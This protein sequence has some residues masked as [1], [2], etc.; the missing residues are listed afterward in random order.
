MVG[1]FEVADLFPSSRVAQAMSWPARRRLKMMRRKLDVI[2]DRIIDERR[3]GNGEP[4]SEDLLDVFLRIMDTERLQFPIDNDNIKAVLY[5]SLRSLY[6]NPNSN[7]NLA[8][9]FGFEL[10]RVGLG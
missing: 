6:F 1:G 9:P 5:V 8:N 7:V 3:S 10:I 2:L 4:G